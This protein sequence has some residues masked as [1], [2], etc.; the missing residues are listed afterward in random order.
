MIRDGTLVLD[1][2][3]Q[4]DG[5]MT[6]DATPAFVLT[7]ARGKTT[8]SRMLPSFGIGPDRVDGGPMIRDATPHFGSDQ[9]G[10]IAP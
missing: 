6:P 2:S 7:Q 5:P 1:R 3:S 4:G 10:F 8:R 9:A